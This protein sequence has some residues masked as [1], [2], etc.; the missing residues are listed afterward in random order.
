VPATVYIYT[1]HYV[2]CLMLAHVSFQTTHRVFCF[3][4]LLLTEKKKQGTV[5]YQTKNELPSLSRTDL[6]LK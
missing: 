3:I 5:G 6:N 2:A 1:E 4:S